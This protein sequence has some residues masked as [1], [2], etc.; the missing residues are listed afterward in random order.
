MELKQ[1]QIL[2]NQKRKQEQILMRQE[3]LKE[4]EENHMTFFSF[5]PVFLFVN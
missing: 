3:Y 2:E 4:Q 1:K 5:F